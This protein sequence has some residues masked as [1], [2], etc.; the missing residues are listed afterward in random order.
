MGHQTIV[1][2]SVLIIII[3]TTIIIIIDNSNNQTPGFVSPMPSAPLHQSHCSDS[4]K[5]III[6]INI[7]NNNNN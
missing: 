1:W 4:L 6:V 7:N 3:I 2:V 5:I